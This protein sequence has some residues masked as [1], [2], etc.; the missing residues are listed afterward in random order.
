MLLPREYISYNQIKTYR[1]CPRQYYYSYIKNITTAIN[2]KI[3]LGVVFH[4]ATD[5]ILKRKIEGTL[6]NMEEITGYFNRSFKTLSENSEVTWSESR[7]KTFQ[8]GLSFIRYFAKELAP[9]IHPLMTEKEMEC[10]LPGSDIRLRGIIDLVEDD[11][12]ITDFKTTTAKWSRDKV[13]KSFLQMVIYKFLYEESMGG[14]INELKFKIIYSKNATGIR[15]Q[16]HSIRSGD[17]D[18]EKMFEII[19]FVIDNIGKGH[20]YK[21]EGYICHFCDFR[22]ICPGDS[23]SNP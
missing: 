18:M 4:D 5:F 7:E 13:N 1:N 22:D 20:F 19:H 15:H 12:S 11:F 17:V 10:C 9:S 23:I 2:D 21:N 8:R 14:F 6:P 3:F 16:E